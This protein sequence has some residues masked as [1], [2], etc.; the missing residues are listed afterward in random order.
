MEASL[1]TDNGGEFD[2][3]EALIMEASLTTG[4][5]LKCKGLRIERVRSLQAKRW[6]TPIMIWL[7]MKTKMS[8]WVP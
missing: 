1:T 8:K 6:R 7:I 4:K 3:R 2:N 5:L